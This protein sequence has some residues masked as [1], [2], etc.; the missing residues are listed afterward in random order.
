M[1]QGAQVLTSYIMPLQSHA[2]NNAGFMG[3]GAVD[4]AAE[5]ICF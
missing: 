5:V 3:S 4:Q 2:W 1:A